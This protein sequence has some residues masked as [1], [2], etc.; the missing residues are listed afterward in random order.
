MKTK[1]WRWSHSCHLVADNR[2]E[3]VR[4]AKKIGMKPEWIQCSRSGLVHF[5]LTPTRR[6][7]AIRQGAIEV[8]GRFLVEKM[9]K[10]T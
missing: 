6:E 7:V 5:D 8:T 2:D 9:R 4:F 10:K 1:G 3:L